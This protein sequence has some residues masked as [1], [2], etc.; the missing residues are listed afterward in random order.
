M[1]KKTFHQDVNERFS[2]E[3][4]TKTSEKKRL[5]L[6]LEPELYERI[7]ALAD[8]SGMSMNK[9]VQIAIETT[10]DHVED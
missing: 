9:A 7:K 2:A 10:L 3:S 5:M 8:R 6:Y 4:K 1:A